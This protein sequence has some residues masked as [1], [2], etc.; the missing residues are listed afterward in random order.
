ML[1]IIIKQHLSFTSLYNL[2]A[3]IMNGSVMFAK[4]TFYGDNRLDAKK[5]VQELS[6]YFN[7]AI[8]PGKTLLFLDEIQACPKAIAGLRYF[9]E[10]MPDLHVVAAGSL[11]DFALR[12]FKHSMPVG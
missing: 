9:H 3:L 10:E 7:Q 4:N 1:C 5:I 8:V 2:M 12:E 11:L 6:L